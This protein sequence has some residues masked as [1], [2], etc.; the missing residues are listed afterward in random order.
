MQFPG[1]SN[2]S[3]LISKRTTKIGKQKVSQS[4][5]QL[6]IPSGTSILDFLKFSVQCH[7]M[8]ESYEI[9][10]EAPVTLY[11]VKFVKKY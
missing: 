4:D 3:N 10:N 2:Y 6:L 8:D 7:L 11:V 5:K 9:I 1:S